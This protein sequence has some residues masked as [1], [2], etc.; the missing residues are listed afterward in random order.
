MMSG[1]VGAVTEKDFEAMF[2]TVDDDGS[3]AIDFAEFVSF[4]GKCGVSVSGPTTAAVD[5]AS[6]DVDAA[7]GKV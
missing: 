4:V 6:A 5:V 3:G 2:A 1:K 7:A